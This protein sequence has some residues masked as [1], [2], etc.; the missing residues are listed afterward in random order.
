MPAVNSSAISFADYSPETQ[1]LM[2]TFASGN[3]YS[4]DFFPQKLYEAFLR[5]SSKGRFYNEYI[6]DKFVAI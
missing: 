4:Y 3:K 6:K 1:R 2:L 5:S